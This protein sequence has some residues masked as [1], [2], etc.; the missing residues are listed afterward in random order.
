[1]REEKGE[2][3]KEK[4]KGKKVAEPEQVDDTA[5]GTGRGVPVDAGHRLRAEGDPGTAREESEKGLAMGKNSEK[6]LGTGDKRPAR[7]EKGSVTDK[8]SV[9]GEKR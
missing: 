6:G 8:V 1:M 2:K 7:G 9:S 3:K 5:L 4:K